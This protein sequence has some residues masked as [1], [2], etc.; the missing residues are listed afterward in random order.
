MKQTKQEQIE[1]LKKEQ[2]ELQIEVSQKQK[3]LNLMRHLK[4]KELKPFADKIDEIGG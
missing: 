3:E 4:Y 2:R 1:A